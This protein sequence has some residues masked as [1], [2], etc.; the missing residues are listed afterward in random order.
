MRELIPHLIPLSVLCNISRIMLGK[1]WRATTAPGIAQIV[2][3][4]M[5]A[6]GAPG[7]PGGYMR[8]RWNLVCATSG[9][10]ASHRMSIRMSISGHVLAQ[11]VCSNCL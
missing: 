2:K 7:K 6:H 8:E 1:P 4:S 10:E 9:V 3:S 5:F 11:M